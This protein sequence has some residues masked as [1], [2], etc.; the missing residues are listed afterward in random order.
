M[1]RKGRTA[2]TARA[3]KIGTIAGHRL[4]LDAEAEI[5]PHGGMTRVSEDQWQAREQAVVDAFINSMERGLGLLRNG[6]TDGCRAIPNAVVET[7]DFFDLDTNEHVWVWRVACEEA[8]HGEE[9]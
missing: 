5:A 7:M 1:K 4:R 8:E 2:A 6:F 9:S 3:V